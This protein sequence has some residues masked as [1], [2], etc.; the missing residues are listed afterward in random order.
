MGCQTDSPDI[1]CWATSIV[2]Q[3]PDFPVAK[4]LLSAGPSITGPTQL[5][6]HKGAKWPCGPQARKTKLN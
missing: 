2:W 3:L 1:N 6:S 4:T 5:G